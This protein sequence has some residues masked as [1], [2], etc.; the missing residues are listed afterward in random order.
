MESF[1]FL[2]SSI[3]RDFGVSSLMSNSAVTFWNLACGF[4]INPSTFPFY[5]T[6]ISYISP[7]LY[8]FAAVVDNQFADL[9][10]PCPAPNPD[11]P[12]CAQFNG[13]FS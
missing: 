2:C 3:F 6:W 12:I 11:D 8:S 7:L 13:I 5:L 4:L 9:E 1:G 10:Y